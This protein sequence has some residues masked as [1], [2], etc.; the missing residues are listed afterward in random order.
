MATL[1]V[2]E[3]GAR[4]EREYGTIVVVKED[5][6][7]ARV[8][9][10]RLT[11]V[12]L[13]G[14]VGVTT[15]A[16]LSMLR[17]GCHLSLV[18]RRGQLQ[19]Q[20]VA[21]LGRN[22]ELR[23]RQYEVSGE[24]KFCGRLV[25][26]VV[27]GKVRNSL[28]LMKRLVRR[29]RVVSSGRIE[30]VEEILHRVEQEESVDGLRG[31]EGLAARTYFSLLR[32]AVPAEFAFTKR[33]RRPPRDPVNALLSLG[34]TLLYEGVRTALEVVGLD[35]Y[36]GFFHAEKYGRPALALDLAEEFRA[37]VV[38]SLVLTLVNKRMI[39]PKDFVQGA[40][41][42]LY[43]RKRGLRVFLREFSERLQTSVMHERVHRSLT[44]Q[45]IF[46]VQARQLAR[47]IKGQIDAYEAFRWR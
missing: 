30:Q 34:Y 10:S 29:K 16:L 5:E 33:E 39:K 9:L 15:P 38:D 21:P 2:V 22:V 18:D 3:Q 12:V 14:R 20:L 35:P 7:L 28:V 37:P 8:P 13:V 31:L 46:E 26:A 36:V 41:G 19:G 43:L 40:D 47:F 11:H 42:G 24:R 23:K 44:Y 45:K 32:E 25:K 27:Y 4:L 17:Q 6:M 1:Y